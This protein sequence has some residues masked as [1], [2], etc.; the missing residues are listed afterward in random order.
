MSNDYSVWRAL[1]AGGDP[2]R[3]VDHP[4]SGFYRVRKQKNGP[5][6]PIAYWYDQEGALVCV[7]DGS[8]VSDLRARE[9][10]PWASANPIAHETYLAVTERGENWPD[11]D[12]TVAEQQRTGIGGNNPP[13]DEALILQEQIEAAKAGASEYATIA[14][15]ATLAKAQS[16]RARLNELSRTA[17]KR[18]EADKKP[19]MEAAKAVDTRWMPLVKMAKEAADAIARAMSAFETEKLRKEREAQRAAEEAARKAADAG[20]PAPVAPPP[21]AAPAPVK[22]AYGR[23]ASVKLI[24]VATVTDRD[25]FYGYV[26]DH[27]DLI[28]LLD[29]LAQR[30]VDAGRENIP[31]VSIEEQRKVA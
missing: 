25:A 10:W 14:D 28:G 21:P 5:F 4:A 17:D 1:L 24:K 29:K 8:P 27:P 22:G 18:R 9:I 30:A 7:M 19:H 2:E 12:P 31:G 3:H 20:K 26:K 16:L 23:A 15:D 6:V 13:E 11:I